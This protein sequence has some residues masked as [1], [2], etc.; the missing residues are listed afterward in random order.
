[1]RFALFVRCRQTIGVLM[2][3]AGHRIGKRDMRVKLDLIIV[4]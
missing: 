1:L 3:G 2:A 4:P